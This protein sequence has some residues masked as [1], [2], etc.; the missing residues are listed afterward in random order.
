MR[1]SGWLV[2]V[3]MMTA[4]CGPGFDNSGGP[5]PA[6]TKVSFTTL[7]GTPRCGQFR[8]KQF[9]LN[10]ADDVSAADLDCHGSGPTPTSPEWMALQSDVATQG[11]A[12]TV[13]VV[14]V[15]GGCS[16]RTA[17]RGLFLDGEKL[18]VWLLRADTSFGVPNAA[19][20]EDLGEQV[21]LVR[22]ATKIPPGTVLDV[23]NSVVNPDAAG[24]PDDAKKLLQ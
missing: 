13:L 2:G 6:G 4:A 17:V 3:L 16:R 10:V 8:P 11:D 12:S 22:T 14:A 18:H 23:V 5:P 7:S 21:L 24:V 20:T 9:L 1:S 15:V 19:C